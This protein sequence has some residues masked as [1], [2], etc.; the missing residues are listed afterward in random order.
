M[1]TRVPICSLQVRPLYELVKE[2]ECAGVKKLLMKRALEELLA[3]EHPCHCQPCRNNGQA[4]LTGSQCLCVCRLGTSGS[5]CQ[6]G[7]VVGEEAGQQS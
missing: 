7:A 5:A 2:V 1:S 6:T 3:A 4:L